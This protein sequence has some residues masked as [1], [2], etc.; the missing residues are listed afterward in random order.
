MATF[1][2]ILKEVRKKTNMTQRQFAKACGI[3]SGYYC[4]LEN[5]LLP[6]PSDHTLLT[7][8]EL[9]GADPAR[10]ILEAGRI[11]VEMREAIIDRRE[12]ILPVLRLLLTMD[13]AQL[14]AAYDLLAGREAIER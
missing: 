3:S 9:S 13:T 1:A 8:A 6:P 12:D 7:I 5:G 4:R 11:P 10:L 2:E 14:R